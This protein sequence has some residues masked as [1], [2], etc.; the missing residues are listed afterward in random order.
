VDDSKRAPA[1]SDRGLA[2]L[3]IALARLDILLHRQLQRY[4]QAH[5]PSN[6]PGPLEKYY[7]TEAQAYS[8]LYQSAGHNAPD[9]PEA[10]VQDYAQALDALDR[11][12][13][14]M[15]ADATADNAHI[16]FLNLARTFRLNQ[17]EQDILLVC[18]A[19][20]LDAR[21]A[22]IYGY[23][24]NDPALELPTVDLIIDLLAPPGLGRLSL[25]RSLAADSTLAQRHLI[26]FVHTGPSTSR[27]RT[28]VRPDPSLV[29][30]LFGAYRPSPTLQG[31]LTLNAEPDPLLQLLTPELH[32][33][34]AEAA[35]SNDL[36]VLYGRDRLAQQSAAALI[37]ALADRPLLTLNLESVA[38]AEISLRLAI[39]ITL[40]DANL[41][42][43][44]PCFL[45]WE[46]AL[47]NNAL[48]QGRVEQLVNY[49]S[50]L[51]LAGTVRWQPRGVTRTRRVRTLAFPIPGSVQRRSLLEHFLEDGGIVS[52]GLGD[53][54]A[55]VGQ[56]SLTAE[57]WRD[58]VYAALDIAAQARTP[59]H[60]DHLFTA[61]REASSPGLLNLGHKIE[62][63]F[64]WDDLVL[65]AE[66]I[67]ILH[68]I[69]DTVRHRAFVLEEWG[70][71]R[72][73]VSSAGTAILFSGPPGTG[74]TMAAE[75]LAR[76]LGLDLYK[77][78]LSG[79]VS[80][81]IGETEKNLEKVFAEAED[82]NAILFFDE[83]DAI[84]GKRSEVSDAHDRHANIEVAYLLQRMESYNGV[85]ILATNLRGNLDE[86]FFRR[87]HFAVDLPFPEAPDRLRIWQA[88]FPRGVPKAPDL[89]LDLMAR[90]FKLAGGNIRNVLVAA[91]YLA[92]ANGGTLTMAHLLHGARREFQKMGRMLN[93]QD[94]RP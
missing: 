60:Q 72:S 6:A 18:L 19:P 4:S 38:R 12:L 92:A 35:M 49:H 28:T 85:T 68:E 32:Q 91:S 75:V 61:A 5:L 74:K 1:D 42:G 71:G 33:A 93:E 80:K 59:L 39:E 24:N 84:F 34:V 54:T 58:V 3:R 7:V 78:D 10:E 55:L 41:T 23:L 26:E 81:Y 88:L 48:T 73:L 11:Q 62:P 89:D 53:L 37:S 67:A 29:S 8:L 25:L 46:T 45:A 50:L 44:I 17:F 31:H 77:I 9:L 40:R 69:V 65:P 43:A 66:Q 56:F 36:L 22:K 70:L 76:H 82:S 64:D 83:A 2:Y 47:E 57:Q 14:G 13:A 16:P 87:L 51:I 86:A 94:F 90:R 27:L 30:W 21:Y 52:D 79:I 63:R 20:E 15:A